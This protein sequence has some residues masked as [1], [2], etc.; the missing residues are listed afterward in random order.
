MTLILFLSEKFA[1]QNH[2]TGSLTYAIWI[3]RLFPKTK[4]RITPFQIQFYNSFF[5]IFLS[6]N[7]IDTFPSEKFA[8][9]NQN[10]ECLAYAR[11]T[12]ILG[13]V[14]NVEIPGPTQQLLCSKYHDFLA[15]FPL[16]HSKINQIS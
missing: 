1:D 2:N 6:I 5:D 11:S 7:D 9:Q 12:S 4:N 16:A 13:E 8:G 15:V 10:T 3:V 14:R